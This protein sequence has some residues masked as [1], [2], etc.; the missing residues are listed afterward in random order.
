MAPIT[1]HKE[2]IKFFVDKGVLESL[3]AY[4]VKIY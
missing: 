2:N 3:G 1:T 4:K